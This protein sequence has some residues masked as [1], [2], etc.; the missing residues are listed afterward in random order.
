[1]IDISNLEKAAASWGDCLPDWVRLLAVDADR[2]G[3]R[4]A[5][6][7]IGRSGGLVSR[8]IRNSYGAEL[9]EIEQLVKAALGGGH[10]ECPELGTIPQK[11][12]LASRRRKAAPVNAIQRRLT[13]ACPICPLNPDQEK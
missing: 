3:Q 11:S 9:T 10:V 6:K 5:G 8:V 1:M 13:E 2:V 7:R 4:Q 12:C